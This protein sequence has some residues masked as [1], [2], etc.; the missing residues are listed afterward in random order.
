MFC[1]GV[2]DLCDLRITKACFK[3]QQIKSQGNTLHLPQSPLKVRRLAVEILNYFIKHK[4]KR[5]RPKT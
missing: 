1:G 4:S 5:G 2:A 3:E